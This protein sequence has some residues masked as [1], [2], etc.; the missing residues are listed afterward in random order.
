MLIPIPIL[1]PIT[2]SDGISVTLKQQYNSLLSWTK[3]NILDNLTVKWVDM[4]ICKLYI[5]VMRIF[6]PCY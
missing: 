4:E 6:E 5:P 1:E 3:G 2:L